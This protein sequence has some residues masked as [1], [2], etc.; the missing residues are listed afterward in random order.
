MRYR[1]GRYLVIVAIGLAACTTPTPTPLSPTIPIVTPTAPATR[2]PATPEGTDIPIRIDTTGLLRDPVTEADRANAEAIRLAD[3]PVRDLRDLAIRFKGLPPD[4]PETEC[5]TASEYDLGDQE[6][7]HV[8]NT[9]TLEQFDVTATLIGK[10]PNVYMWVDNQWLDL[11][12]RD[13]ALDA[14]REFDQKII[15]RN[16]ALFGAEWS[17]GIDCDPRLHILNTS[18]TSAG[19]YFSSTDSFVQAVRSD[20]NE[21]EMFVIDLEGSGGPGFGYYLQVLAHE[22]Q[23]MIHF[24]VD[25]NE[26]LW[27]NE[28]LSELAA[29]LNGYGTGGHDLQSAADPDR[30]LNF[31][32]ED[33]DGRDYGTA[34][35]FMLYLYDRYGEAGVSQ[36][37]ADP[38][39]GL[40][41]VQEV[42]TQ[43][44]YAGTADDFFADWVAAKF[45]DN[46]SLDDGRYGFARSD[47]PTAQ[48]IATIDRYPYQVGP[49]ASVHQY[50]AHYYQFLGAEDLQ[51]DFAGSTRVRLIDAEPHSGQYFWWSNRGDIADMRL[52]REVDLADV[53]SATLTYWTWFDIETDYDYGYVAVSEDGGQTWQTLR[54]PASTDTSP[55]NA[56]LGWGYTGDSGGG[57]TPQWIQEEVDL[58]PYA[59]KPIQ[60]RFESV[61]DDGVNLPGFAIDDIEIPEIGFQDD[62]E[63]DTGWTAEGWVRTNNFVPQNFIVQVIGYGRD[64]QTSV[65]RLPLN[66]DNTGAWEIP[67]SQWNSAVLALAAT[68]VK[69]SEPAWFNLVVTEKP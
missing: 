37:V 10:E 29:Y 2:A 41:A 46:P 61:H 9:D 16:R 58:T 69:S 53:S 51:L 42:L 48:P 19:G 47:P 12:D 32:S 55:V 43:L 65:T 67:L 20:S 13:A 7:F 4:T 49:P 54:M 17:P 62:A 3:L 68:A 5:T 64:G 14:G 24:N 57:Q 6:V 33:F 26:A 22:Y 60:L 28:G 52:T 66:E 8:S 23:H 36:F 56:N 50:A 25:R 40:E 27:A 31:W 21:R 38:H 59:G 45:L 15:P 11:I 34:F 39:N 35:T 44:G 30:Q 1:L 63:A 18:N